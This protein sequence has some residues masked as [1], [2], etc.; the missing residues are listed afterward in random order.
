MGINNKTH[1]NLSAER[2]YLCSMATFN[3]ELLQ[4]GYERVDPAEMSLPLHQFILDSI[5]DIENQCGRP[6]EFQVLLDHYLQDT[7]CLSGMGGIEAFRELVSETC[8]SLYPRIEALE[9]RRLARLRSQEEYG[10]RAIAALEN[11]QPDEAIA[12]FQSAVHVAETQLRENS[13]TAYDAAWNVLGQIK[14]NARKK[15]TFGIHDLD[16]IIGGVSPGTM[17]VLGGTTGVGKSSLMLYMAMQIA[18]R[19]H[20]PGIVSCEDPEDVWG[21]RLVAY[22]SDLP[23]RVIFGSDKIDMSQD[24]M[25][26]M[27]EYAERRIEKKTEVPIFFKYEIGSKANAVVD[28]VN[29]LVRKDGCDIVFVDYI[30]AVRVDARVNRYDKAVSDV[31]KQLKGACHRLG[32]PLILG[33][34][35]SRNRESPGK[36]PTLFSLKE[37]G[38]L[39]NEA[40]VVMLAWN[41]KNSMGQNARCRIAKLKWGMSGQMF[42][43]VRGRNGMISD[44][45]EE[46]YE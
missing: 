32:V 1:A 24:E 16:D 30:Q 15:I 10:R 18:Q 23:A 27:V 36:E 39:E 2:R 20:V 38:D 12:A 40:E 6:P 25:S 3:T 33:S 11:E 13:G 43:I 17:T 45:R 37:T 4:E 34:Q 42:N 19:G 21:S 8:P 7:G 5:Y 44:V 31:A 29:T 35:L 14:S 46:L 9:I 22:W 28:A 41:E 26:E